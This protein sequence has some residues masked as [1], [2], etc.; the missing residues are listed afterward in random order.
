[1]TDNEK[2]LLSIIHENDNPAQAVMIAAAVILGHLKRRGSSE[3][4][5]AVRSRVPS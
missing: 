3:E 1:M 2:E 4:P 5:V